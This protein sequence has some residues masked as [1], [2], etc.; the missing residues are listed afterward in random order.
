MS[1]LKLNYKFPFQPKHLNEDKV[2]EF[3]YRTHKRIGVN[4]E[5]IRH[6]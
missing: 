2:L 5:A 1:F 6:R 4:P 3:N